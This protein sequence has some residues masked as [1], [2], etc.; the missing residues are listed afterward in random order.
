MAAVNPA[1]TDC[2]KALRAL[3][4]FLDHRMSPEA[5]A[6][7]EDHLARCE[8]CRVRV[9]F[10]ARVVEAISELRQS[11]SN[12]VALR[13]SVLRVLREAGMGG[14]TAAEGGGKASGG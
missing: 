10:E 3:W 12:P 9:E 1:P 6:G 11:H 2:D 8:G 13:E 4:D 14:D 5:L 7:M